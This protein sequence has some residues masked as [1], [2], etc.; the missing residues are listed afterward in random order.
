[1]RV[2][3]LGEQRIVAGRYG[4]VGSARRGLSARLRRHFRRDKPQRWHLDYLR[5][6]AEPLGALTWP[7]RAGLECRLAAAVTQAGLGRLVLPRFGA[8][9]CSC[10]G[11]L[12]LLAH[13][14]LGIIAEE[15]GRAVGQAPEVWSEG[16]V[17]RTAPR[18]RCLSLTG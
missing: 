13:A 8:S 2:G 12:L 14:E 7:W 17:G 5:P 6:V 1:V 9:D 4:Y 11:H 10:P 15:L 18:R 16:G 3:A